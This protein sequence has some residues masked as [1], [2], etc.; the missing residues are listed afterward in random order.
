MCTMTVLLGR[1]VT[2]SGRHADVPKQWVRCSACSIQ[3][4][5]ERTP[6][7]ERAGSA[8]ALSSAVI[9]MAFSLAFRH[10]GALLQPLLRA[11]ERYRPRL[12]PLLVSKDL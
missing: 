7:R 2:M 3:P 11:L 4:W 1:W 9:L 10:E 6:G 5:A 8:S 12:V